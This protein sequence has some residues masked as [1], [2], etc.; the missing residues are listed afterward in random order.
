MSATTKRGR[1]SGG[2]RDRRHE[3]RAA[4]RARAPR[5]YDRPLARHVGR[6]SCEWFRPVKGMVRVVTGDDGDVEGDWAADVNEA[7]WAEVD[8][9]DAMRLVMH[10]DGT[11]VDPQCEEARWL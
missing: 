3:A 11:L 2:G 10:A 5:G 4:S 9:A 1:S 7:Q 6:W 8:C